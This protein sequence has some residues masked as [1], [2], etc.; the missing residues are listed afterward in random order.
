MVT[1]ATLVKNELDRFLP[2]W[3]DAVEQFADRVVIIDNGSTD[4]SGEYLKER[5]CEVTKGDYPPDRLGAGKQA[6]FDKALDGSEWVVCIDADQIP[7]NDFRPYL[8]GNWAAFNVYDLWSSSHYRVDGM[9][10]A[11]KRWFWH[12]INV[13]DL[14]GYDWKWGNPGWH[15]SHCPMNVHDLG[16]APLILPPECGLL[17]YAYTTADFRKSKW[18]HYIKMSGQL[19]ASEREHALSIQTPVPRLASRAATLPSDVEAPIS[20]LGDLQAAWDRFRVD[21]VYFVRTVFHAE[22]DEWQARVMME[23]ARGDRG[24]S[25]RSGH[26]VGK[27]A[28]LAWISVWFI[29]TRYW[30]KVILTAPTSAQLHDALLPEV[31]GWINTMPKEMRDMLEVKAERIELKSDPTR[32]F[33]SARTS[34]AEQPDALQGVHAPYVLLIV[35]EAS[36]VPEQV[37]EASGGSMSSENATMILT[38]NPVRSTGYFYDTHTRLAEG[39][40]IHHVSC[41]DSKRVSREYI[42][43]QKLRY[44]EDSNAYRIRVLGEFPLADDDTVIPLGLIEAAVNRDVVSNP[45]AQ[46][47]WGLDVARFGS[48]ATA[49]AKRQGNVLTSP[50]LARRGLDLMQVTGWLKAEY[51]AAEV[52]P[53]QINVDSIGLGAGVVDRARELDL[54]VVG[55]NVSESPALGAT[56]L[57]LRAEL[58]YRTKSWLEARDSRIP[59]DDRL[60]TELSTVRFNFTSSGRIKIESKADIKRRGVPSP[61]YADSLVLTFATDAGVALHG[62]RPST[63]GSA[64]KRGIQRL[65]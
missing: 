9:W 46:I 62:Y 3:M 59:K 8:E 23:V 24:I 30:A 54:P 65:A 60:I 48:D 19:T 51:D 2:S 61:D 35:D 1:V 63:W 43:E 55:I 14:Q 47:V 11:H 42:E 64:I 33:I 34:R 20:E 22:P 49:L 31:K 58:W 36:G 13:K 57:N 38:G 28:V 6:V 40:T 26:G 12:I 7:A 15:G 50:I 41:L 10:T 21:P 29:I 56:Y 52:K 5:G 27:T 37:Y 18:K 16:D 45:D 25:V 53:T 44:G 39:W 4:G 17:H 32:N